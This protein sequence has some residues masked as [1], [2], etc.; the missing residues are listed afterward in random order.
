VSTA[1]AERVVSIRPQPGPQEAFLSSLADIAIVGGAAGGGKTWSLLLEPLRHV[2]NKH[3]GAVIFRRTYPQITNEGG[4]WDEAAEL[5]PHLRAGRNENDLEYRFP[6]GMTVSF[7]HLQHGKDAD[8]WT[9]AQVPLIGFDQ[10]EEFEERQFWYLLTR[11][12]SARAG[13][14][15]YVRATCNPVPDDD[16]VGGWLNRLISWWWDPGTGYAIPERSGVLRWFVRLG[17]ELHWADTREE[18]LRRFRDRPETEI[19]PKSLTFIPA[20]LDD[21]PALELADPDYR[22]W[23]MAQPLV[24]R[25]RLL[26]GNWKIKATKGKVFNREWFKSILSAVP[27]DVTSWV[28]YWDKAGTEGGGKFSAG[29][30]VGKRVNGRT[31]LANVVR[32]QWSALNRETIIKQTAESDRARFGNVEIWTEQE[33]GSGGKE[34]AEATVRMLAGFAVHADR[35]TGDK[36]T[37]AGPLAAQVEAGNVDLLSPLGEPAAGTQVSALEAFLV[38]AQNF[39]GTGVCDQIDA[40]SGAFNKVHGGPAP[41]RMV[42]RFTGEAI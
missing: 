38:E 4:L 5:Y 36:V 37:R 26:K 19:R 29:V 6:S 11:N 17:E 14:R 35:V 40:A 15:P 9:G 22:A 23:L 16:I 30:L 18:L 7:S 12:R 10:L 3:F 34:S 28:R 25:E 1:L 41:A 13:V 27:A 21:N 8:K 31:V 20:D 24:E 2:E 33:P 42:N 39:D 32:G